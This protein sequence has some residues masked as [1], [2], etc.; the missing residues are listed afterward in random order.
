VS[1]IAQHG[2]EPIGHAI[3]TEVQGTPGIELYAM[4][5]DDRFRGRGWGSA[6]LDLLIT[7]FLP[8]NGMMTARCYPRSVVMY[9]LLVS[10]G[11]EYFMTLRSGLRVMCLNAQAGRKP[12]P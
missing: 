5:L 4:A 7:Q 11:F 10:R 2:A 8:Q 1:L 3:L 12:V 6:L 9:E